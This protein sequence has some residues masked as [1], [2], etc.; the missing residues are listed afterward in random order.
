VDHRAVVEHKYRQQLPARDA[1]DADMT[2]NG[3]THGGQRGQ[4]GIA[5]ET[6]ENLA[7]LFQDKVHFGAVRFH[8]LAHRGGLGPRER[9][10]V[11]QPVDV[12]A[13]ALVRGDTAGG[14]M[15]L[16]KVA[17]VRQLSH[18]I[19]NG[20]GFHSELVTLD[21]GVRADRLRCLD[22]VGNDGFEDKLLPR[23][24]GSY[25]QRLQRGTSEPPA[26]GRDALY[27]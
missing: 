14:G 2:D 24:E 21:K 12:E 3:I 10:L 26:A 1:R 18:L 6:R 23:I 11:H 20:G 4:R 25:R 15:R 27:Y 16:A 7:C 22:V 19:A 13:V 17:Q 9:D 5:R 8:L